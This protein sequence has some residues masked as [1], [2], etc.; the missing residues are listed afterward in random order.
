MN[1]IIRLVN[2]NIDIF[3]NIIFL[4][5]EKI[6]TVILIF[7]S[8]GLI[9][10][11]LGIE[12]YGKWIYSIN[13]IIILSSFSLVASSEVIIPALS[14]HLNI[15]WEIISSAFLIRLFF[16]TIA[17]L[18]I[19]IY[20]YLFIKDIDIKNMLAAISIILLFNE[21]FGVIVNYYQSRV[22]IGIISCARI[23]SLIVRVAFISIVLIIPSSAFIYYSRVVESIF[24]SILLVTIINHYNFKFKLQKKIFKIVLKRGLQMWLPLVIMFI[25]M[26]ADRFFVEYYLG[27]NQLALYGISI[28]IIEQAILL[29][30]IIIQSIAPRL[31]YKKNNTPIYK[32]LLL[33]IVIS[34]IIQAGIFIFL[35]PFIKF[36]FGEVYYNAI[37]LT[38]SI[39]PALTFYVI[40]TVLMQLIYRDLQ[41]YLI[42]FKWIFMLLFSFLAYYIWFGLFR[43]TDISPVFILNYAVMA[44]VTYTIRKIQTGRSKNLKS[45]LTKYL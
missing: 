9:S 8:E 2:K 11:F 26:R 18:G 19:N 32:I 15:A 36:V 29:I 1:V 21:P 42:I 27:F 5:V 17:Y 43:Y 31:L 40:D 12:N 13:F 39:L 10:H 14:R 33:M 30:G 35:E 25:Y 20:F 45:V 22:K 16:A 3:K 38:I 34:F 7:Y 6:L 28:Q 44:T 4:L 24:L 37:P 23:L 41:Y